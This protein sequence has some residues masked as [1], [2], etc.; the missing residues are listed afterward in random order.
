MKGVQSILSQEQWLV[1]RL[2]QH[3]KKHCSFLHLASEKGFVEIGQLLIDAHAN[4][5]QQQFDGKTPLT[6][7]KVHEQTEM[8]ELL[9]RHSAI[10][11]DTRNRVQ[12]EVTVFFFFLLL[13]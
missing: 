12:A 5:N 2:L 4:I 8:I 10:E 13:V 1:N 9:Q 3:H 7:A 11:I 6:I